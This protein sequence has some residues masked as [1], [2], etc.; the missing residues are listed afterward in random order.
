LAVSRRELQALRE[1]QQM[2]TRLIFPAE[3]AESQPPKRTPAPRSE[4]RKAV[5]IG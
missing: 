5:I 3:S 4:R 1:Q 2:L